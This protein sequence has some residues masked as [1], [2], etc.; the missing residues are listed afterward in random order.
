LL[1]GYV[2]PEAPRVDADGALFFSDIIGGGVHRRAPEGAVTTVIS[3]RRGVGGMAFHA[4][5]GLVVS[6]RDV[7]HVRDGVSRRVLM[8]DGAL[9]FNDLTTDP[10]GRVYV[11]SMRSGADVMMGRVPGE[12]W[13]IDEGGAA[14][15]LYDRVDFPNGVGFSPDGHT[16]YHS[17]YSAGHVLAHVISAEGVATGRRVFARMPHGNPDGLAVDEAGGVWVALGAARAVGRFTPD[18]ALDRTIELPASFVASLCFGGDD[19]RDLY[20]VGV[21]AGVDPATAGSAWRTRVDVPGL[22]ASPARV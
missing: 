1:S 19:R 20:V 4:D 3:K 16:L 8:V 12:L 22:A 5:G 21:A 17:D 11:G 6:G 9:G 13:R 15:A 18:G 7:V 10:A 14:R 2:F